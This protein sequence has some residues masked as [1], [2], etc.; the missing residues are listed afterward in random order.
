MEHYHSLIDKAISN[1]KSKLDFYGGDLLKVTNS[2]KN[3]SGDFRLF[4]APVGKQKVSEFD[5]VHLIK[6]KESFKDMVDLLIY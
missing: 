1:F 5:K 4:P 6:T 2:L 3:L